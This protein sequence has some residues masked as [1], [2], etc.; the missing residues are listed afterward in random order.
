MSMESKVSQRDLDNEQ[1]VVAQDMEMS[2]QDKVEAFYSQYPEGLSRDLHKVLH[3]N[4]RHAYVVGPETPVELK[5][6][7]ESVES[8]VADQ[9]LVIT[10]YP[11]IIATVINLVDRNGWSYDWY[12]MSEIKQALRDKNIEVVSGKTSKDIQ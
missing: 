11:E 5:E 2:K 8:V 6:L 7:M 1:P 3:Q 4:N 12:N 9:K 10:N